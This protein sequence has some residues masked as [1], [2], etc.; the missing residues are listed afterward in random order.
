MSTAVTTT[1]PDTP[2]PLTAP[3]VAAGASRG[4]KLLTAFG[5]SFIVF[6]LFIGLWFLY[7]LVLAFQTY[8]N[9]DA[10]VAYSAH[11]GGFIFGAIV[12]AVAAATGRSTAVSAPGAAA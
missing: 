1:S 4:R 5:P 3:S 11:V 8:G 2:A 7:Q 10:G 6:L 12:A 9:A